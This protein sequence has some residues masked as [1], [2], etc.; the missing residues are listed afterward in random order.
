MLKSAQRPSICCACHSYTRRTHLPK[1]PSKKALDANPKLTV[2]K[3]NCRGRDQPRSQSQLCLQ[4]SSRQD[5]S[6]AHL[7]LLDTLSNVD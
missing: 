4:A 1:G 7:S 6:V 2:K 3:K 5:H